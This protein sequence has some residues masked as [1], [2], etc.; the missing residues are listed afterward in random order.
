MNNQDILQR[1]YNSRI[2]DVYIKLIKKRYSQVDVDELLKHAGME[3][4]QVADQGHWFSQKQVD[5]FHEKLVELSG[6]QFIAREAGQSEH[7]FYPFRDL[8]N[9]EALFHF[10]R[11]Y[12]HP[13]ERDSGKTLPV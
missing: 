11:D 1:P 5:S 12:C 3:P 4:Y 9:Q 13:P 8:Q 10:C 7:Q 6:N 2:I